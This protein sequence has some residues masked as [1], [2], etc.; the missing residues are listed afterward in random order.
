MTR[1]IKDIG[2]YQYVYE[3]SMVWDRDHKKRHKVSHYVGKMIDGKPVRIRDAVTIKGVYEIGHIELIFSLMPDVLSALRKDFPEDHKAI[4]AML[5]NRVIYPMPLKSVKAWVEKTYLARSIEEISGKSLS[6]ML[7]RIGSEHAKQKS[8]FQSLMK[9]NEIIAY[10]TSALFTYSKGISMAEFGHNNN[11][12]TLPQIKIILGF[13]RSRNEPC[14]IRSDPGSIADIETLKTSQKEVPPGTLFVMDRGF[15]D[16]DNFNEMDLSGI[17]FI[18]PLRRNSRL[19]DYS[20]SMGEFF[21]FR[22]RAIRYAVKRAGK[23]DLHLY[24]DILLKAHEENEHYARIYEGKKL[25]FSPE[26]A[27]RIAILTNAGER[28]QKVFELYKFRND[29][30]ESFDVMK[31]MLQADTPYL[32]DDDSLRGYIFVSF[33]SLIAYYR[34]LGLLKEKGINKR[35]SVKDAILQLSKIYLA[36]IGGRTVVTEMPKKSRE[37]AELLGLNPDLFPKSVPS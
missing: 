21:M 14:Y 18:T 22:E 16:D 36:D 4:L 35:I 11:D 26:R 25:D 19:I 1:E 31:N 27:G 9:K 6:A 17:Y 30:E 37:L 12:I 28:S 13:S 2:K 15:I 29:V 33:L 8:M 7:A 32:R 34:I 23:Y 10:D 24:E 5:L 3:S 20:L